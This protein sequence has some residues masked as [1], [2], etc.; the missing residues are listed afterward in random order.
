MEGEETHSEAHDRLIRELVA[1]DPLFRSFTAMKVKDRDEHLTIVYVRPDFKQ[2]S[3]C[4]SRTEL[5]SSWWQ[6]GGQRIRPATM[7][8]CE[9]GRRQS[10]FSSGSPTAEPYE[11]WKARQ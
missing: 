4:P 10:D 5:R 9:F 1:E 3:N 7:P 2:A 11:I 8:I 6:N